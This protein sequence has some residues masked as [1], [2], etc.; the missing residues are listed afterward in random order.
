MYESGRY[1]NVTY[2]EGNAFGDSHPLRNAAF[3][4]NQKQMQLRL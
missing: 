3:D 4:I 1:L 2:S